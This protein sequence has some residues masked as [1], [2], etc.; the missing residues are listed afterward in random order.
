MKR[1]LCPVN[2]Q[3][4]LFPLCLHGWIQKCVHFVPPFL[5]PLVVYI[6]GWSSAPFQF[7]S[8]LLFPPF[9]FS[10]ARFLVLPSCRTSFSFISLPPFPFSFAS[11]ALSFP[12]L[13]TLHCVARIVPGLFPP[14]PH[15]N[16]YHRLRRI[17]FTKL[18]LV[19]SENRN[20]K[21]E[22]RRTVQYAFLRPPSDLGSSLRHSD[23]PLRSA[24][25]TIVSHHFLDN[26]SK[27]HTL[28]LIC[29]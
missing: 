19:G 24:R 26:I 1:S 25:G 9:A 4:S 10:P 21:G 13:A 5:P 14:D 17:R 2:R 15:Q 28:Y 27:V 3:R 11:G 6:L 22:R 20:K 29:S 16:V 12:Y 7:F 23:C 18:S 8:S